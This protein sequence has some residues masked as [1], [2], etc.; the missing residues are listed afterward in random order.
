MGE[1]FDQPELLASQWGPNI[2]E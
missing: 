2:W 1:F